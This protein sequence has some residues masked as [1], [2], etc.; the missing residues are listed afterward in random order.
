MSSTIGKNIRLTIF[1]ESHGPAIGGVLEGLPPGIP[2]PNVR[3]QRE[4]ERRKTGGDYAT[5]RK[6]PDQYEILSGV[7][8]GKTTGAPLAVEIRNQD[9]RSKDYRPEILRPSHADYTA[10]IRY[11]GY[12]DYRGG[13]HFS[14]RLTAPM[15][16]FG[17]IAREILAQDGIL[18][19]GHLKR[20]GDIEEEPMENIPL[21]EE[22][23]VGEIPFFSSEKRE[24]AKKQLKQLMEEKDSV[25]GIVEIMVHNVPAGWGNPKFDGIE[26]ALAQGIFALG[27]VKGLEFGSGF[28]GTEKKGSENNDPFVLEK[29]NI[30]TQTNHS[31]GIQGGITNGMPI[32][33]RVAIKPTASIGKIQKTV[34]LKTQEEIQYEIHGRHDPAIPIRALPVIENLTALL[35]LDQRR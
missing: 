17:A 25:G 4:M 26:S 9:A 24:E 27:G 11:N 19:R 29:G 14:G 10:H 34:N 18:I 16:F 6:E 22:I 32:V 7:F 13:G 21:N 15:V 23:P 31:G 35:L 12:E 30:Q 20:L 5:P 33:F 3:I 8:Q 1:G 2:I 28:Q